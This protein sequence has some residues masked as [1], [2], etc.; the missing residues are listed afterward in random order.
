MTSRAWFTTLPTGEE[1][2]AVS[3]ITDPA[4]LQLFLDLCSRSDDEG[5]DAHVVRFDAFVLYAYLC[6]CCCFSLLKSKCAT[7]SGGDNVSLRDVL[8]PSIQRR[9]I[10]ILYQSYHHRF[11]PTD[12]HTGQKYQYRV[13]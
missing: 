8:V 5:V 13:I 3:S 7:F 2:T 9:Q 4:F 11:Q 6:F 10:I 1:R 12:E